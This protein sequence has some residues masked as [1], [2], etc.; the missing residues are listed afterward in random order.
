MVGPPVDH[1]AVHTQESKQVNTVLFAVVTGHGLKMSFP[2]V[3]LFPSNSLR[4]NIFLYNKESLN[5]PQ[6]NLLYGK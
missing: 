6:K 1:P 4:K 5:F 2:C 3:I